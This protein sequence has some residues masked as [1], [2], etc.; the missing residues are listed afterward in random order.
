MP[1]LPITRPTLRELITRIQGDVATDTGSQD[2]YRRGTFARGMSRAA[3]AAIHGVYGFAARVLGEL[4]PTSAVD[5]GVVRWASM[6]GITRIPAVAAV[7]TAT[8]TFT[9]SATV[10]AGA[11]ATR[12]DGTE[13]TLAANVTRGSAGTATGTWTAS[14]A[15]AAGSLDVGDILTLSTPVANVTSAMTVASEVTAGADIETLAALNVRNMERLASPPQ[16]GAEA[17]YIAWS[18]AHSAT[19]RRVWVTPSTPYLGAVSVLF[20]VEGTGSDMIPSGGLV[21]SLQAY[22]RT[23]APVQTAELVF[24]AAPVGRAIDMTISLDPD[25]ST[26]QGYVEDEL[27]AMF[28]E[29][30]GTP[31]GTLELDDIRNAIRLGVKQYSSTGTFTIDV[32]EGTTPADIA[33][34]TDE[35]PY[36]GTITW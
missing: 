32:L 15:G 19:I 4:L 1:E 27:Y 5:W 7:H 26:V 17:D 8:I 23:L 30:A 36:L 33:L 14:V 31:G 6:L 25:N 9:G 16:G 29:W 28:A 13:Y 3:A 20:A 11:V 22:L 24:V 2:V 34:A 18:K 12:S 35:L 21:T 10:S